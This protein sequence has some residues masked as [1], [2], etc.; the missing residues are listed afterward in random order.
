MIKKATLCYI[1]KDNKTL[2]LY[3]NKKENDIHEGKYVDLGGKIEP[4]ETADECVIREIKEESGLDLISY[5]K[6]GFI[7]FKGLPGSD[8]QVHIYTSNEFEGKLINT[9]EG[10]LEWVLTKD[11]MKLK[12][13]EAD[14]IFLKYLFN[15]DDDY[16]AGIFNY[17]A[18]AKLKNYNLEHF[19]SESELNNYIEKHFQY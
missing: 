13:Q 19:K 16:F 11:I 14:Y 12:M 18:D 2:M 7:Y 6:R 17:S 10:E 4:N 15:S 1:Q 5:K 9:R 3:R 8:W